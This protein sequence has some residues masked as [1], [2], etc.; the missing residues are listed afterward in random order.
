MA[1]FVLSWNGTYIQS[2][3][4]TQF[5]LVSWLTPFFSLPSTQAGRSLE[6]MDLFFA[7]YQYWNIRKVAHEFIPFE[8]QLEREG[9][10]DEISS[11]M[12]ERV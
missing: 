4:Q 10:K 3:N 5:A 7:K 8:T 6:Q 11:D 2:V 1:L 12:I 9:D